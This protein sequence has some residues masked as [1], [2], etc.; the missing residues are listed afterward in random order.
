MPVSKAQAGLMGAI[1]GGKKPRKKTKMSQKEAKDHLRGKSVKR[2]PPR[3]L[4][5]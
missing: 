1:A 3:S 5:K 4:S 2:L